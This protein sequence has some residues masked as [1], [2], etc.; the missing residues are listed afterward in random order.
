[1]RLLCVIAERVRFQHFADD[2]AGLHADGSVRRTFST[3][4]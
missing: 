1:V 4:A 3:R 2:P